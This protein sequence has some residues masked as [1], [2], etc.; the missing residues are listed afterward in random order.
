M[1]I[2]VLFAAHGVRVAVVDL[3]GARAAEVARSLGPDYIGVACDVSNEDQC[4]GVVGT[5]TNEL[6]P[7]DALV[8]NAGITGRRPF[9]DVGVEEFDRMFAVNTRGSFFMALARE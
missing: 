3:D 5:V 6:G 9:L 7:I 1:A 2:A 4:I 8:S